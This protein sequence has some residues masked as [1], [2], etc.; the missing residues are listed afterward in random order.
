MSPTSTTENPDLIERVREK[1]VRADELDEFY[2]FLI[3]GRSGI[4]K[5]RL[6]ATLPGVL[7][8]DVNDKGTKSTRRS[9]NPHVYPVEFWHEINDVYWFLQSGN[10]EFQGWALDTVTAMSSLCMKFILGDEASR[11]ASKDPDMPRGP[12]YQKLTELMKTQITNF[13]NLP[14]AGVFTAQQQRKVMGEDDDLGGEMF[15]SPMVTP[16]VSEALESAVDVIGYLTKVA[17]KQKVKK[18]GETKVRS[19]SR[20]RL[21]VDLPE[22]R[23]LT[24]DRENLFGTHVDNPDLST[25]LAIAEGKE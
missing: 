8:I 11:D 6:A 22:D 16:K 14:M 2:H 21:L 13:R 19:I 4:G 24:K 18:G 9:S 17:V 3:Y 10:H 23:Y 7:L 1:I 12:V 5:T 20:S 15:I 25:M